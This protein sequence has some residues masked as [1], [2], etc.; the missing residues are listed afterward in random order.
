LDGTL[1]NSLPYHFISIKKVLHKHGIYVSVIYLMRII[2]L[3]TKIIFKDFKKKYKLKESVE[4]LINERRAYYYGAIKNRSMTFPGVERIINELG[5]RYKLAIATGS[6]KETLLHS[7][8]MDFRKMFDVIITINDTKRGKPYPDPFLLAVKKLKVKLSECLVIGDSIYDGKA[9]K[10]AKID[11]IGVETGFTSPG[12]LRK[13][14]AI[15]CY[16]IHKE[17]GKML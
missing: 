13:T 10:R 3:A 8:K 2:G 11:F 12:E 7:T 9:A 4:D 5:K 17:L 6:S 14:G 1:I 16:K 15:V